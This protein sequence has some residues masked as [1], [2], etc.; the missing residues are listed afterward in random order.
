MCAFK[1]TPI[2]LVDDVMYSTALIVFP[3]GGYTELNQ[4]DSAWS[5]FHDSHCLTIEEIETLIKGPLAPQQSL[6]LPGR[7]LGG[8]IPPALGSFTNLTAIDL[9][10]NNLTGPIPPELSRLRRLVTLKLAGNRLTGGIPAEFGNFSNNLANLFLSGNRLSGPL[11]PSIGIIPRLVTLDVSRNQLSGSIPPTIGNL[12]YLGTLQLAD[13]QLSG[14]IPGEIGD[15]G[16]AVSLFP[17][18]GLNLSYNN[19]S[20]PIPASLGRLTGLYYLDLSSNGLSGAFPFS[21]AKFLKLEFLDLSYN[22]LSGPCPTFGKLPLLGAILLRNNGFSGPISSSIGQCPILYGLDLR[23]NSFSGPIPPA[24]GSFRIMDTLLLSDNQLTGTVPVELAGLTRLTFLGIAGNNLTG[25]MPA[26]LAGLLK[27]TL[28]DVSRNPASLGNLPSNFSRLHNLT[29]LSLPGPDIPAWLRSSRSLRAIS[30][31]GAQG[32]CPVRGRELDLSLLPQTCK[33]VSLRDHC[34]R[35]RALR[36]WDACDSGCAINLIGTRARLARRTREEVCLGRAS[37]FLQGDSPDFQ[38]GRDGEIFLQNRQVNLSLFDP[39]FVDRVDLGPDGEAYTGV[40]FVKV[41]RGN[42]CGNSEALT[43]IF[44]LYS[45]FGAGAL[46]GS[47]GAWLLARRLRKQVPKPEPRPSTWVTFLKRLPYA[48]K[49]VT[50][51]S[52]KAIPTGVYLWGVLGLGLTYYDL[53]TDILVLR[54]LYGAWPFWVGLASLL[55]SVVAAAITATIV[56]LHKGLPSGHVS[57]TFDAFLPRSLPL[58]ERAPPLP[59]SAGQSLAI[60]VLWPLAVPL[61]LLLDLLG[62]LD[63]VGVHIKAQGTVFL[64]EPWLDARGFL[65]TLLRSVPSVIL[66]TVVY[67]LG[68]SRS[69]RLY[70]DEVLFIQ[71]STGA[72]ST[73]L[74]QIIDASWE[75]FYSPRPEYPW[76]PVAR[77]LSNVKRSWKVDKNEDVGEEDSLKLGVS[78]NAGFVDKS[79]D[80]YP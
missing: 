80:L 4:D 31:A 34:P 75:A 30:F 35:L 63:R 39:D 57:F 47:A 64:M 27:L 73:M 79:G 61:V 17:T 49:V 76:N 22:S 6:K 72:L 50:V 46:L 42:L 28:L 48:E 44:I 37:A 33:Y 1:T 15:L 14:R 58:K 21:F 18:S 43:V 60:L 41:Q 70:F 52:T 62:V 3:R 25:P 55:A 51:V 7:G 78:S 45:V 59:L 69:T 36:L 54:E 56:L 23:N 38:T 24:L 2:R 32:G 16:G 53:G 68:S 71:S 77:R 74:Y 10:D 19:L 9:S 11:P 66:Q 20:G 40:S 65:D 26:E 29:Q 67:W 5:R 8:T 12:S 13:N